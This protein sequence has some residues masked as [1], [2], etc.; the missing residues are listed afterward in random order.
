[1]EWFN[2][3]KE[4]GTNLDRYFEELEKN[5]ELGNINLEKTKQD[6]AILLYGAQGEK[7]NNTV[8]LKRI[9]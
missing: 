1:M 8:V 5:S 9:S 6:S 4:N 2:H 7:F 3:D